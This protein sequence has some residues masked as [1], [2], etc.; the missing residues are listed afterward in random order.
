[1]NGFLIFEPKGGLK[2]LCPLN[3]EI[4]SALVEVD[5]ILPEW[6]FKLPVAEPERLEFQ[7][8]MQINWNGL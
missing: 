3:F 5:F 4:F 7:K 1:M 8:I 2:T 6:L